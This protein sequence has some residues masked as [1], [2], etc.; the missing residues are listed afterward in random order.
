LLALLVT[1]VYLLPFHLLDAG[2]TLWVLTAVPVL[3]VA[4]HWLSV[5]FA[6]VD[7]AL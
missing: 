6:T 5:R 1:A 2:D 3:W 4:V 7:A